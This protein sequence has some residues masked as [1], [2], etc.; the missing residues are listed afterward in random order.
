[1]DWQNIIF[2][3]FFKFKIS[4]VKFMI[5]HVIF[6]E[7]CQLIYRNGVWPMDFLQS[8][9]IPME[10]KNARRCED[11]RTI[12]LMSCAS[13][14]VLTE[15]YQPQSIHPNW[16]PTLSQGTKIQSRHHLALQRKLRIPKLKYKTLE[17]SEAE[18]PFKRKVLTADMTVALDQFE[19]KVFTHYHCCWGALWKQSNLPI[20]YSCCLAPLK[21]S[22][23]AHY[24]C[25]WR[26]FESV[27]SLL[28]QYICYCGPPWKRRTYT[29]RLLSWSLWKQR[30]Y[31]THLL[32]STLVKQ[33]TRTLQLL[34]GPL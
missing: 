3:V 29:L 21:A 31:T 22:Y 34:L 7:L 4:H 16:G 15:P 13:K 17:I 25:Y 20:H 2:F 30:T 11:F 14:I 18:G 32:L 1:M 33:S 10:N 28:T 24:S 23:F 9:M 19:S 27:V 12:S 6:V 26:P 5:T 8:V